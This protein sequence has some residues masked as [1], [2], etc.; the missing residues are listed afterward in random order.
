MVAPTAKTQ[1]RESLLQRFAIPKASWKKLLRHNPLRAA[2]DTMALA[3]MNRFATKGF[4]SRLMTQTK[5]PL[6]QQ[7]QSMALIMAISGG[8]S[9]SA[10]VTS[11]PA[12]SVW[13]LP[14]G[15]CA[16]AYAFYNLFIKKASSSTSAPIDPIL[17]G[18]LLQLVAAMMGA[19]LYLWKKLTTSVGWSVAAG[20]AVGAAEILSFFISGMGVPASKSIPTVIGGSVVVGTLAGSVWLKERLSFGG[21]MGVCLIA[22]GIALVGMDPGSAAGH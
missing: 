12:S 8:A 21:W 3:G 7:S 10:A 1:S 16:T 15:I 13:I 2:T 4:P 14:A 19:S 17:G 20:L 18:V 11:S 22:L 5:T 6:R 9:G